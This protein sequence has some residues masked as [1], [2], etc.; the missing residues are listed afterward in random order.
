MDT[1]VPLFLYFTVYNHPDVQ[2]HTEKLIHQVDKA[3]RDREHD[4][5]GEAY[6]ET[7]KDRGLAIKLGI[8]DCVKE[9]G[10]T[11]QFAVD[12]H[13]FP[14]VYFVRKRLSVDKLYGIVPESQIKEAVDAFIE[15]A[16]KE[17]KNEKEGLDTLNRMKRHDND[18]ENSMT[19]LQVAHK[20]L[21]KAEIPKS[22]KL[23]QKAYEV[24]LREKEL[25]DKKY[26]VKNKKMTVELW[27]KLKL[28]GAYNSAPQALCGLGM[29]HLA[30]NQLEGAAKYAK[31]L[32]EE[33]PF[34]VRD[35]KDVS[36]AVVRIEIL[37]LSEFD[38]DKDNYTK[39]LKYDELVK[40]PAVF[41]RTHLKLAVCHY[42]EGRVRSAIAECLRL[43][44]A[45]RK[46]LPVLKDE[47]IVPKDL[48]LSPSPC[49]PARVILLKLF[50]AAGEANDDVREGRRLYQLYT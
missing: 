39:L 17:S 41:Y 34:A 35:M 46:L 32:R 16:V 25:V 22:Q 43:V 8:V 6:A 9:P 27:K 36:A 3:N 28:E 49:T 42:T 24:A 2:A 26:G 15:Y 38:M 29:C 19:L 1:R 13:L 47:G 23:F 5:M 4:E 21:Q 48:V 50:E 14:I 44:R 12:P 30:L 10:L 31:Q 33:Y 7:G 40:D 11:K 20:H 45:E 18:D 37:T